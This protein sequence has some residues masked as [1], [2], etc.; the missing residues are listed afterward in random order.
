MNLCKPT[1]HSDYSRFNLFQPIVV[2]GFSSVKFCI[3]FHL[4]SFLFPCSPVCHLSVYL[5]LFTDPSSVCLFLVLVLVLLLLCSC[6]VP[7][8]LFFLYYPLVFS[9][10]FFFLLLVCWISGLQLILKACFSTYLHPCVLRLG[11]FVKPDYTVIAQRTEAGKCNKHLTLSAEKQ[12]CT[13]TTRQVNRNNSKVHFEN[14]EKITVV[15]QFS[16]VQFNCGY[17][18]KYTMWAYDACS[19]HYI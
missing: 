17:E 6:C 14:G 2:L 13:H 5:S 7:R 3:I 8:G 19:N 12:W 1:Y 9:A 18:S 16:S 4:P 15:K 11:P 10:C